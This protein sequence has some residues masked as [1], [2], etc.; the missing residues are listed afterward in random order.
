MLG[1]RPSELLGLAWETVDPDAGEIG[2]RQALK[3]ERGTTVVRGP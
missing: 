1:L 2:V 3:V